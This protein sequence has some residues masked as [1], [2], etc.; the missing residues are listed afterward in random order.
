MSLVPIFLIV[1]FVTLI[2]FRRELHT[3]LQQNILDND[4]DLGLVSLGSIYELNI[5][6]F[7]LL[8]LTSTEA[9]IAE[10]PPSIL[11]KKY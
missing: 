4:L 5:V 8:N 2:I 3:V 1:S 10:R 6:S 9:T 7:Y 11:R